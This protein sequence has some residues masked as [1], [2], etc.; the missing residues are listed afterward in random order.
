MTMLWAFG[1]GVA[2]GVVLGVVATGYVILTGE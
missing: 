1:G 2:L